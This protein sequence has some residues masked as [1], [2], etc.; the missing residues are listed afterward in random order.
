MYWYQKHVLKYSYQVFVLHY[1]PALHSDDDV[2][3]ISVC[4]QGHPGPAGGPGFPGL[5]GCNGTRGERGDPGISGQQGT[6]GEPVRVTNTNMKTL[7]WHYNTIL[8]ELDVVPL[9]PN[10]SHL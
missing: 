6:Y 8:L 9:Q 7:W 4:V 10:I 3:K 2:D 5:D 1:F